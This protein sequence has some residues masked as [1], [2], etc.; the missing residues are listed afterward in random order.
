MRQIRLV[1]H[2]LD[3]RV[4]KG[5]TVG[6]T[7]ES[8]ELNV[9]QLGRR[10]PVAVPLSDLKAVFFVKFFDG[11]PHYRESVKLSDMPPLKGSIPV[12]VHFSDG[13][14]IRGWSKPLTGDEA[15]FVLYPADPESNNDHIY[16]VNGAGLSSI[17]AVED[18]PAA[19]P[20]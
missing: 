16:I 4:M 8:H 17:E 9:R 15:G 19:V 18:H 10:E 12:E 20:S 2:F 3:G 11:R 13:E 7:P 1:A 6:F 5:T 14:R